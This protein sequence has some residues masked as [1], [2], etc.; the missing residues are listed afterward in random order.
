MG[1]GFEGNAQSFR[2]ITKLAVRKEDYF[3]MNFTRATLAASLKYPWF[4]GSQGTNKNKK[5][6]AYRLEKKEFDFAR[7]FHPGENKTVEAELME[8]ADDIAYSVHDLE[9][10]HRCG[11]VPWAEIFNSKEGKSRIIDMMPKSRVINGLEKIVIMSS[12]STVWAR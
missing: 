7:K 8:W 10:F 11:A 5:W 3:G 2:I 9:D 1:E 12:R 6:S 4:R